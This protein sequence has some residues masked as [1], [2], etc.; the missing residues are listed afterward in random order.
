MRFFRGLA[1]TALFLSISCFTF[2]AKIDAKQAEA[3]IREAMSKFGFRQGPIS[4]DASIHGDSPNRNGRYFLRYRDT[5]SWLE[6]I[7]TGPYVE[8]TFGKGEQLLRAQ[9][10][11]M[12]SVALQ[13]RQEMEPQLLWHDG[14]EWH[15]KSA[16]NETI[17]KTKVVCGEF[18]DAKETLSIC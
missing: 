14:S 6:R 1:A 10:G 18:Q 7:E 2:A 4:I 16:K 12:P 15:L 13:I 9:S 11:P 3:D 5:Q 17:N 8:V